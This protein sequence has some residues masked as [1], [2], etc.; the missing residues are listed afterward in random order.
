MK[1]VAARL[2]E[3]VR[4]MQAGDE[5]V[6]EQAHQPVARLVPYDDDSERQAW[7]RLSSARL[8]QA[9][10]ADEPEYPL[11]LIKE[12]NASYGA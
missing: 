5:V 4:R 11:H 10:D 3:L 7:L 8:A 12:A 1:D 2:V 6:L 9:Y